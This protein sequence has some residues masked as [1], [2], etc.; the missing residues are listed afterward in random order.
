LAGGGKKRRAKPEDGTPATKKAKKEQVIMPFELRAKLAIL[1]LK[2]LKDNNVKP[3]CLGGCLFN[4]RKLF[5]QIKQKKDPPRIVADML[6]T[7]SKKTGLVALGL[8]EFS[9]TVHDGL[10]LETGY[11]EACEGADHLAQD[12]EECMKAL[13]SVLPQ[14][15]DVDGAVVRY[16][17]TCTCTYIKV[18][19]CI[20]RFLHVAGSQAGFG[21][22][23][24]CASTKRRLHHS[25]CEEAFPSNHPSRHAGFQ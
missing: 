2:W 3:A 21:E 22:E 10:R 20:L 23:G 12:P 17:G 11:Q 8:K 15:V 18:E 14:K 9:K 24:A 16:I 5:T 13:L 1:C 25:Q 19:N 6:A 7:P 4:I